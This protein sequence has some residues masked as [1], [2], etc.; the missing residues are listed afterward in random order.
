MV[1]VESLLSVVHVQQVTGTVRPTEHGHGRA[2]TWYSLLFKQVVQAGQSLRHTCAQT[3]SLERR[4]THPNSLDSAK[5]AQLLCCLRPVSGKC[6]RWTLLFPSR[7]VQYSSFSLR[8]IVAL[9]D[10]PGSLPFAQRRRTPENPHPNATTAQKPT[11]Y[12][13]VS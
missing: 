8:P 5:S 10:V 7:M 6:S 2:H 12:H 11:R 9:E 4:H 3:G 13:G 1:L